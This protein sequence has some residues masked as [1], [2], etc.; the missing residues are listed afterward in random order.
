VLNTFEV[1]TSSWEG[2]DAIVRIGGAN[3]RREPAKLEPGTPDRAP[4]LS[5]EPSGGF[6]TEARS[7]GFDLSWRE[8]GSNLI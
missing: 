7:E 1:V 8:R 3:G 5:K 4:N 6:G 2:D